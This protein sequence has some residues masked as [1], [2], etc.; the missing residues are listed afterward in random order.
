VRIPGQ[1]GSITGI[2]VRNSGDP[3]LYDIIQVGQ[4]TSAAPTYFPP[5]K[6]EKA[7][8][9]I[10]RFKDGGFG[11]NNPSV[12]VYNDVVIKHGE[13]SIGPFLSI[14]TGEQK[15]SL[16]AEY[17]GNISNAWANYTAM[18]RLPASTKAINERMESICRLSGIPFF[19]FDGG[20]H[21]GAIKMDDWHPRDLSIKNF[22]KSRRAKRA[23]GK[24]TLQNIRNATTLYLADNAVQHRLK[25]C[26]K[27][28]VRRRRLRTR[29]ASAWERYALASHFVCPLQ[30]CQG[31]KYHTV[32]AF[33]E[34]VHVHHRANGNGGGQIDRDGDDIEAEEKLQRAIDEARC[35]WLYNFASPDLRDD[36]GLQI[37][38]SEAGE[39][40]TGMTRVATGLTAMGL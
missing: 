25:R 24:K 38:D 8:G 37:R 20:T 13:Q 27:L 7:D 34:H 30:N 40:A 6:I 35:C 39:D 5:K 32:E 17:G 14:G 31:R 28:L 9:T 19:R 29:D 4:S 22:V 33:A 12:E 21:L 1:K 10:V 26:A 2:P 15:I 23:S 3:Q 18:R 16:F 11:C 36:E